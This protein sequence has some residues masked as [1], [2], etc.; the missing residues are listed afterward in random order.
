MATKIAD[1]VL[2][3]ALNYIANNG[4]EIFY[5]NAEPSTYTEASVTFKLADDTL[6][7]GDGGGNYVVGNGDID[8]RK[9]TVTPNQNVI[10]DTGGQNVTHIAICDG[11]NWLYVKALD[12]GV[13]VTTANP[14]DPAAFD[15]ELG[16]PVD[17]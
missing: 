6:A 13:A 2:D 4:N 5:C 7:M 11:T 12:A 14:L 10:V 1:A 9:L 3:A 17:D 8:G 16:D 15:I